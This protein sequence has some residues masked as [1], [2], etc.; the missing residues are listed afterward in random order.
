MQ[1]NALK[2]WQ[3]EQLFENPYPCL[4]NGAYYDYREAYDGIANSHKCE[5]GRWAER[6]PLL[7]VEH[8]PLVHREALASLGSFAT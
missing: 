4:N 8:Q 3:H 7:A 2:P 6:E 1:Y 5:I